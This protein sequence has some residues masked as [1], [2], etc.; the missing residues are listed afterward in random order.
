MENEIETDLKDIVIIIG[1]LQYNI[2]IINQY[3][4]YMRT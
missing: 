4:Y 3:T 1:I 2:I